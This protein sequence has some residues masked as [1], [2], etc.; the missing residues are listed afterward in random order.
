MMRP[1]QILSLLAIVA[2]ALAPLSAAAQDGGVKVP[3]KSIFSKL[4]SAKKS[5]TRPPS[6]PIR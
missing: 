1:C 6:S 2:A 5:R 4:V 3:R